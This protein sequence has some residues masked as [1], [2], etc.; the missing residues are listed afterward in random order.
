MK[1]NVKNRVC[2]AVFVFAVIFTILTTWHM[3]GTL[4]D[5]DASS[6][7]VLAEHLAETGRILSDRKSV[8]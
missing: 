4:L 7:L 3:S 2:A 6:E 5:S 8:V 1:G